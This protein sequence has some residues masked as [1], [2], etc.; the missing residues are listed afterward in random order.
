[1]T[2]MHTAKKTPDPEQEALLHLKR[3]HPELY[4]AALPHKGEVLARVTPRRTKQA[5]FERLAS[6]IVSQQLST[7]AAASIFARLKAKLGGSVTPAG[8]LKAKSPSLRAVG[9]SESKVKSIKALSKAIESKELDLLALKKATPEDAIA[10]L[11]SIY[12]IGQWTAE[13]FLIFAVGSP[14]VFS[15][16]DLILARRMQKLL[17]LPEKISNKEMA[18]LAERWSPHRSYVSLLFW[19]LHH[20]EN[21]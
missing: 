1:M 7:K 9:L 11:S 5:L 21:G 20:A 13:M 16:G 2:R 8:I 18:K 19:K 17:T 3:T 15:P 14:D 4:A 10:T 12:G 6:S